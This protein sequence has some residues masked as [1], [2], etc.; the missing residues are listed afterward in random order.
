[1]IGYQYSFVYFYTESRPWE[2]S[3]I[4]KQFIWEWSESTL[5]EWK[6]KSHWR[7]KISKKVIY[8]SNCWDLGN[9]LLTF[10]ERIIRL[11]GKQIGVQHASTTLHQSLIFFLGKITWQWIPTGKS[12]RKPLVCMEAFIHLRGGFSWGHKLLCIISLLWVSQHV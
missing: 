4:T 5:T 6:N 8:Q 12:H 3:L 1:M 11:K 10:W 9:L 2:K 7:E